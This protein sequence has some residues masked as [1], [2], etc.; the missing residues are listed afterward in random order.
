M[1][2]Y[3]RTQRIKNLSSRKKKFLP[4]K[5]KF[6]QKSSRIKKRRTLN[7][8][9]V[10]ELCQKLSRGTVQQRLNQETLKDLIIPFIY[11]E[12]QEKIAAQ[13]E[14]S[15]KLRAE[16]KKLL[17]LAKKLVENEIEKV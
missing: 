2:I 5:K 13:I 3:L 15:F 14:E 16:S 12:I 7:A 10:N 17:E 11:L 9:F 8:P 6:I 4:S 1:K